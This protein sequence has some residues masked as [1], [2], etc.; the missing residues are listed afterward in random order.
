MQRTAT[1]YTARRIITMYP[2][3]PEAT[4]VAVMEGRIVGVGDRES[5]RGDLACLPGTRVIEDGI[6][7][8]KV[9]MPGIV[10]AHTHLVIP[11][12]EYANHFV[13]QIP[14]PDPKGGFFPHLC[15]QAGRP[16][17]PAGAGRAAP[18][19]GTAVGNAL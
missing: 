11:A 2:E 7:S 14:W 6:F 9:L 15:R 13:P 5:L 19:R 8:G 3:Q 16:G 18:R 10:E 12:L 1:I 4:A 17:A